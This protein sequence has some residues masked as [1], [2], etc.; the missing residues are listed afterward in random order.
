MGYAVARAA[1][2][3][4]AEVALVSGPTHLE[5]PAGARFIAVTTAAE[6]RQAVL[7]EFPGCTA[8]IMAAAVTDYRPVGFT[9]KKIKRG[10]GPIDIRLEPNVDILREIGAQKNGKILVGFAAETE[11]LV[12][13]AERKL[14]AKNL[15]IIVANNVT[16]EGSGFDVDTNVATILDRNGAVHALPLMSKDD[17]AERIFDHLLALKSGR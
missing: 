11:D 1:I 14:K 15:D 12:A 7:E 13:N 2:R 6:M 5:P 4:G 17:L 9:N 16:Q 8:V 10:E 3:R